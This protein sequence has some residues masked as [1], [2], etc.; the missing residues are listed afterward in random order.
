MLLE[1][2]HFEAEHKHCK[3]IEGKGSDE[4]VQANWVRN[5]RWGP[6]GI[7]RSKSRKSLLAEGGGPLLGTPL[8]G[9]GPGAA[10]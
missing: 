3:P 4:H 9:G 2:G 1:L 10:S 5:Q 7:S 8:Q 6:V